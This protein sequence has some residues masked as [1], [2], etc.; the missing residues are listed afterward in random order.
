MQHAHRSVAVHAEDRNLSAGI[1]RV[2][3]ILQELLAR[4][5]LIQEWRVDRVNRDDGQLRLPGSGQLV[6]EFARSNAP[7][8]FRPCLN[9]LH[10]RDLLRLAIFENGELLRL[11]SFDRTLFASDDHGNQDYVSSRL[12]RRSLRILCPTGDR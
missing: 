2:G 10:C 11:Q 12:E 5:S 4:E 1:Q 8:H 6:G 7:L 3:N 9:Q